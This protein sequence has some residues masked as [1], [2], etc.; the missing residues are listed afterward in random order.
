MNF[1]EKFKVGSTISNF[2]FL[3]DV[4]GFRRGRLK[5]I[6]VSEKVFKKLFRIDE[7]EI[8]RAFK[9]VVDKLIATFDPIF[10]WFFLVVYIFVRE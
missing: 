1:L 6:M 5:L 4:L 2:E 10:K 3:L 8:F 9:F 7:A